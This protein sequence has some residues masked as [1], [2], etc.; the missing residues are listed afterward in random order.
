MSIL[1]MVVH[2]TLDLVIARAMGAMVLLG[3]I[4][5]SVV[6][7]RIERLP[8]GTACVMMAGEEIAV[9]NVVCLVTPIV[10]PAGET[11]RT[12]VTAASMATH[13]SMTVVALV[14]SVVRPV[15]EIW[16]PTAL[17]VSQDSIFSKDNA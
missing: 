3:R 10:Y 11:K 13:L 7:I 14:S 12:N 6:S 8:L 2:F 5:F 4:A 9:Q 1:G 15:M 17:A 16:N